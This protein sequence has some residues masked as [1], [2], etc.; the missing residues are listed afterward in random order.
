MVVP[1]G[2]ST[3]DLSPDTKNFMVIDPW[4]EL[5]T[6]SALKSSAYASAANSTAKDAVKIA[7]DL[8]NRILPSSFCHQRDPAP[9]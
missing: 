8:N 3:R 7:N 9:A 6:I 5:L 1:W 2:I 4:A